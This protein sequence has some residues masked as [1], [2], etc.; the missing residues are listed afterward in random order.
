M[1]KPSTTPARHGSPDMITSENYIG[2][3]KTVVVK[4]GSALLVN[5]NGDLRQDGLAGFAAD[6]AMLRAMGCRCVVVS[7][8][9]IALGRHHLNRPKSRMKLEEKQAAA[10]I[11]QVQLASEW[12]TALGREGLKAAQILLSPEDTETRRR[13]LNARATLNTLLDHDIIPVVN[14]NDTV[15]TMEIRYGDN[16]RLAARVAQMISADVLMLLSDIDG[17]YTADPHQDNNAQHIPAVTAIDETIKAMAGPAHEDYASGGMITKIEAARIATHAGC[18]MAICDGRILR[19]IKAVMDGQRATWFVANENPPQARKIWI[20]GGL[21]PQGRLHLDHGAVKA[22][23]Q[24][25]SLLAAGITHVDGQFERGDL[26]AVC[27]PEDQHLGR[28]LS[29]YSSGD[30]AKIAGCNSSAI[31]DI[32]GFRGRDEVIH[33]DDLVIETPAE[34]KHKGERHA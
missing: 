15:A 23:R 33:A 11:G 1:Q 26:I 31:P 9:A 16:D 32:L 3:A 20:A 7:S 14:E 12:T 2:Q 25:K 30:I 19:P 28:G 18:H 6:L 29:N 10:A 22:L 13:H 4:I 17:L 21:Q 5:D 34:E 8:G 27:G 24:G